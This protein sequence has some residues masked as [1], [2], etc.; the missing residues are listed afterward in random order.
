M[1]LYRLKINALSALRGLAR[2]KK[3]KPCCRAGVR[4]HAGL[5]VAAL[6]VA[7]AA[8]E[9]AMVTF[10]NPY[11]LGYVLSRLRRFG[12]AVVD[13]GSESDSPRLVVGNS[14]IVVC[15]LQ[16]AGFSLQNLGCRS[17][18]VISVR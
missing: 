6:S 9:I 4:I 17:L 18:V 15:R 2:S 1:R 3:T 12:I 8:L 11:G 7:P 10:P 5:S 14:E 16:I 13:L